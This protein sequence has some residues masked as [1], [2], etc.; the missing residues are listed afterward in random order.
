MENIT[1]TAAT[2]EE[3]RS[4]ELGRKLRSY[5]YGFVGEYPAEQYIRLSARDGDGRLLGGLRSFVFLYWLNI[6]VLFVDADVRGLGLGS[7]LLAEAERQAIELGAKNATLTTFEW[8][9]PAFYRKHGYEEFARID[10]YAPGFYLAHMKKA[11]VR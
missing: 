3:L 9:A 4:G 5:N 6:E 1:I 8:Q 11:L 7:R 10:D 2:P